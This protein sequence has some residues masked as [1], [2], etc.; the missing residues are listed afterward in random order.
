MIRAQ[1]RKLGIKDAFKGS[2]A[3]SVLNMFL[4]MYL[5]Y[6]KS[7]RRLRELNS[8]AILTEEQAAKPVKSSDSMWIQHK[9]KACKVL[10]L[11]YPVIVTHLE[12]QAADGSVRCFTS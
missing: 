6:E 12:A 11:D 4:N 10:I 7:A 5:L 3:E 2:E 8:I 1:R 9:Y